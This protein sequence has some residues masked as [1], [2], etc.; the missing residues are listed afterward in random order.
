MLVL[1]NCGPGWWGYSGGSD[2]SVPDPWGMGWK[3]V[4]GEMVGLFVIQLDCKGE[5]LSTLAGLTRER[6]LR[7]LFKPWQYYFKNCRGCGTQTLHLFNFTPVRTK[8]PENSVY[9]LNIVFP[10][11]L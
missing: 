1:V 5:K 11:G 9:S 10:H 2:L 7:S 6:E 4:Q 3:G 8:C